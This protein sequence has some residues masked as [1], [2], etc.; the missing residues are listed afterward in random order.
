MSNDSF[1]SF[2][3][4]VTKN[5]ADH[6]GPAGGPAS[7]HAVLGEDNLA[8]GEQLF[9]PSESPVAK[10]EDL[11]A[12]AESE[13]SRIAVPQPV[14]AADP[15]ELIERGE[16]QI[17]P[18]SEP[19]DVSSEPSAV[20]LSGGGRSGVNKITWAQVGA[21]SEPG[22]YM[23]QFGWIFVTAEDIA[24]WRQFPNASFT[25]CQIGQAS[26]ADYRLGAFDPGCSNDH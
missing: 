20:L 18:P 1:D 21:I 15:D 8:V 4:S 2:A 25:L 5:L 22:R 26:E 6:S 3:K 19:D 14:T 9:L 12:P 17:E 24:V 11:P 23:F 7:Y 10:F 16:S 13:S